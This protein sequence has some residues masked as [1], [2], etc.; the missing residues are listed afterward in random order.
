MQR[1]CA[2][3][4]C[5]TGTMVA[6]E[7]TRRNV[8]T[9]A[10]DRVDAGTDFATGTMHSVSTGARDT[11]K[12]LSGRTR[13]DGRLFPDRCGRAHVRPATP[14]TAAA[15]V[16]IK[17]SHNQFGI[18]PALFNTMDNIECLLAALLRR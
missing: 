6:D 7:M 13:D 3:L 8:L 14:L 1:G 11:A 2:K 18:S 4:S 9:V 15:K 12:G 5:D 10:E 16:Q 17:P